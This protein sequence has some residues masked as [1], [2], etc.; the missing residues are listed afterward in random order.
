[1]NKHAICRLAG[2]FAAL[3][4]VS[5]AAHAAPQVGAQSRRAAAARATTAPQPLPNSRKIKF[6]DLSP[7]TDLPGQ[8]TGPGLVADFNGDGQPDFASMEA[9]ITQNAPRCR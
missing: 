8:G 7:K 9:N 2:M 1:M 6:Q 5:A 4:A 3:I